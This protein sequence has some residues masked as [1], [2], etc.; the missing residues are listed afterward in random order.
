MGFGYQMLIN[1]EREQ[2]SECHQQLW[3][4]LSLWQ[5]ILDGMSKTG[6]ERALPGYCVEPGT[7]CHT[8]TDTRRLPWYSQ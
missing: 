8:A 2:V 7:R 6:R 5:P 3:K 4:S 1:A